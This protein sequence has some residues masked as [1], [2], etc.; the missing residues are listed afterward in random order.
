MTKCK[1]YGIV[2]V[3]FVRSFLDLLEVL[4]NDFVI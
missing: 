3:F 1:R 2:L 4:A